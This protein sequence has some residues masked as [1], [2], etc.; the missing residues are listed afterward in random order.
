[1]FERGR[2]LDSESCTLRSRPPIL[3]LSVPALLLRTLVSSQG[4]LS[5][6]RRQ[7]LLLRPRRS[8]NIDDIIRG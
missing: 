1:M 2:P 8:P 7:R 6:D 4:L 3:V 5:Q